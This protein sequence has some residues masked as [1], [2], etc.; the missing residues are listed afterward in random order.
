MFSS[1][2]HR[3]PSAARPL[4]GRAKLEGGPL[5]SAT[6][7]AVRY[8]EGLPSHGTR[9]FT[10]E[11]RLQV[12]A[13]RRG[14]RLR[15]CARLATGPAA[16]VG[17]L[18]LALAAEGPLGQGTAATIV[19]LALLV[20]FPAGLLWARDAW[21][22]VR[23]LGRDVAGG[24]VE[25]F[26]DGRRSLVVLPA[27]GRIL[28]GDHPLARRAFVGEVAPP[29]EGAVAW[30]MP[31]SDVP[32]RLQHLAWVRRP[33]GATERAEIERRVAELRRPPFLLGALTALACG[34]V[35]A[36]VERAAESPAASAFRVVAWVAVIG[37][38]WRKV[39]KARSL[40]ARLEADGREGWVA[41]A[42]R[43]DIAGAEVLPASGLPWSEQ[44]TPS[45]WRLAASAGR[46]W[47]SAR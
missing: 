42:T 16:L 26:D 33:L 22:E 38:A 21:R 47:W 45:P 44:G 18:P 34:G 25:V 46:R 5:P 32:E 36:T 39:W 8:C 7:R 9:P 14:W 40:G 35:M 24:V 41:R 30:A 2:A 12:A 31:L 17:S 15:L 43:G 11:E 10:P 19:V 23:A 6:L 1:K 4:R 13:A 29:A 28:S 20:A 37:L 3:L 27:S